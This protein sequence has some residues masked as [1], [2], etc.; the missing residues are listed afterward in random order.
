MKNMNK[1]LIAGM[2]AAAQ[3][4]GSEIDANKDLVSRL[5]EYGDVKVVANMGEFFTETVKVH[6]R[7]CDG[8]N[9]DLATLT[10][11][12]AERVDALL[13]EKYEIVDSFFFDDK[14]V[15]YCKCHGV[16]VGEYA[17]LPAT[18][19]KFVMSGILMYRFFEGK[20]CEIWSSF[21][22]LSL[23][24]QLGEVQIVPKT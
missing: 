10:K 15:T 18:N 6:H 20:I 9:M 14:F 19:S 12:E 21:D 5:L 17:G 22:G 23:L 16:H 7:D 11:R 1:F 8:E 13:G 2:L 24:R 3:V 4:G